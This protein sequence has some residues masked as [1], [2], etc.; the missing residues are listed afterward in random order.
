[1]GDEY[2]EATVTG[3]DLSPIQPPYVPPNVSFMLDDAED[4]WLYPG[5]S[6][7]FVHLRHMGGAIQDW[8]KLMS[9]IYES[10]QVPAV[11]RLRGEILADPCITLLIGA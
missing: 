10:V 2:P 1:V 5:N 9:H 6:L 11:T 8:P 3:I 4:L 7:D